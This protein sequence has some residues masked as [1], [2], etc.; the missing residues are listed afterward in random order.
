[1][2]K[3]CGEISYLDLGQDLYHEILSNPKLKK[4]Y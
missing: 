4:Q 1:M 2:I 3:F